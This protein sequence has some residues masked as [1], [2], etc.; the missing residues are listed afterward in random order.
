MKAAEAIIKSLINENVDTVFGYPGGHILEVYEALRKSNIRHVLVRQEQAAAHSASGYARVSG[1]VG[2]CIATSGP[3]ATNLITGIATAYMDSIPLVVITGQVNSSKIGR[4]MF[5]EADITGAAESFTKHSYL[6]KNENDLPR[7]I[8]EAFYIASTGRPGP[9]LID[10]PSDIQA[11]KIEKTDIPETVDIRG[12]KPTTKGHVGQVKRAVKA[13][14]ESKRPL[15]I[16]GGGVLL[17]HAEGELLTFVEKTGIPLV[18]TLMGKGSLPSL[19]RHYIGMIGNHG[20]SEANRAVAKADL[21]II[22]GTRVA[23]RAWGG[24]PEKTTE[25]VRIIHIDVDPAEIGKNVGTQIPMVGDAKTILTQMIDRIDTTD[26][27]DTDEW[28]TQLKSFE[29]T[30]KC[31]KTGFVNP[32]YAM[33]TLSKKLND[34]AIIV[35]DVGQNQIWAAR[36]FEDRIGRSFLTSGGLGTMGYSLPAA[37]GAKIAAPERQVIAV[38]GDGGFQMSLH[39]LGTISYYNL[40]IIILLFN[41]SRLG[42]VRELQ[43]RFYGKANAVEL[44]K[45]PDFIKLCN[46]FRIEGV[47]I[48]TD[49]QLEDAFE[50]AIKHKGPFLLECVVDPDESTLI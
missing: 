14:S 35:A 47:R 26:R 49:S 20:F 28:L 30:V 23:D 22:I 50:K 37:A 1:K 34:E 5:Q 41:N 40:E 36:Y 27:T 17:S 29:G 3:G 21:L 43:D 44:D 42:M 9:V 13:I 33:E 25:D 16:A 12:Y 10:I 24:I 45:N 31:R 46:A 19:N 11:A 18:H 39:E 32:R 6:V 38:V 7:I 2:V 8:K 4:D 15:I 48:T